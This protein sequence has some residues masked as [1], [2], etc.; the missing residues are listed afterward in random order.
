MSLAVTMRTVKIFS[1]SASIEC[2]IY[3]THTCGLASIL[4]K[5][6][7]FAVLKKNDMQF[8]FQINMSVVFEIKLFATHVETYQGSF[9]AVEIRTMAIRYFSY[10]CMLQGFHCFCNNCCSNTLNLIIRI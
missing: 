3:A 7:I 2:S 6:N 5:C 1:Y 10:F 8:C 4:Y 9:V